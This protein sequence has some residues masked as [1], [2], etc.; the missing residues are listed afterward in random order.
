[1]IKYFCID[2]MVLC[3]LIPNYVSQSCYVEDVNVSLIAEEVFLRR[4]VLVMF[5]LICFLEKNE[6]L[7][8]W[9]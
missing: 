9:L 2:G 6:H 4:V 8:Y 1:M 5:Y 3:D 7:L